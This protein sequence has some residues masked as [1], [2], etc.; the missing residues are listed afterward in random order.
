MVVYTKPSR[1]GLSHARMG[2]AVSA[3]QGN[4]VRRNRLKR[5]LREEFRQSAK[6]AELALDLLVVTAQKVTDEARLREA[7]RALIAEL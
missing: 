7:F 5:I 1:L 4:A 3:K 2:L 6:R